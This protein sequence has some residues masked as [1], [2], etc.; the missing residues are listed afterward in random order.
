MGSKSSCK[1]ETSELGSGLSAAIP[2]TTIGVPALAKQ[3]TAS[4]DRSSTVGASTTRP[5]R[6]RLAICRAPGRVSAGRSSMRRSSPAVS[7]GKATGVMLRSGIGETNERRLRSPITDVDP[8]R[9]RVRKRESFGARA[10]R[11]ST[12][13]RNS[14]SA[15]T[16][17]GRRS[18]QL[19]SDSAM[20]RSRLRSGFE[21][22]VTRRDLSSCTQAA[23]GFG[24]TSGMGF[25]GG[26][27][28]LRVAVE[29]Q[30]AIL[31]P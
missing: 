20:K 15:P 22:R 18:S 7:W 12:P 9:N 19:A 25:V 6:R 17:P 28:F 29:A 13:G 21:V 26:H 14:T 23:P 16:T 5:R 4:G 1:A 8:G 30:L 24:S 3:R 31:Q 11:T 10:D 27:R 2:S